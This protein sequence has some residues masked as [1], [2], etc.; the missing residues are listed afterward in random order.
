VHLYWTAISRPKE[1]I[2]PV[3]LYY[4]RRVGASP[5]NILIT[6]GPSIA[7]MTDA[8]GKGLTD[9]IAGKLAY[10]NIQARNEV[11]DI[12]DNTD[13]SFQLYF[14]GPDGGL[15]GA[16]YK[17]AVYVSNGLYL[18]QYVP[19]IAGKYTLT[20]TL[21]GLPIKGS[22]FTVNI[23][24]GEVSP[25]NS[26]TNLGLAPLTIRA[27]MTKFFTVTT[28]D[29]Y[30]NLEV[31]SY[32]DTQVAIFAAYVDHT[33]YASP[34]GVPDLANWGFVYGK[35]VSGIALDRSD[36]TY[37]S[38]YTIFRAGRFALSVKVNNVD[39]KLSPYQQPQ[40][41]YL[42][43][44]PADLYAPNCVVKQVVLAYTAGTLSSFQ[45]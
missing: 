23:I 20:I 18:A 32:S 16:F 29:L 38:Q 37:A 30:G 9:A 44:T 43:V 1:I 24:P 21:L 34:I 12:I 6:K 14:S 17:T 4:P 15:T 35:D 2:P 3:Y 27:G 40:S 33:T 10:I 41:D 42:Y 26:I 28:Y 13:D 11:G 36:G 7:S 31:E 25:L 22:P 8:Y 19:Q 5:Y 45:V 39:V